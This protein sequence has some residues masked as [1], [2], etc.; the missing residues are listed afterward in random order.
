[1]PHT[2]RTERDL[3]K[4]WN[5]FFTLTDLKTKT[6]VLGDIRSDGSG[7]SFASK[8]KHW[9][10]DHKGVLMSCFVNGIQRR[11]FF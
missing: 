10:Q 3:R 2:R 7:E 1:M 4:K 5:K 11:R 6:V 9:V 8:Q